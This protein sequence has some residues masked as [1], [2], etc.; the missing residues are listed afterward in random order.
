LRTDPRRVRSLLPRTAVVIAVALAAAGSAGCHRDLRYQPR[1]DPLEKSRFFA[2]GIGARPIPAGTVARGQL[3]EDRNFYTGMAGG[4]LADSFPMPVTPELLERGRGRYNIYCAPCHDQTG[5]G[6]G[7]VVRRGY[8]QPPSFHID[9]LRQARPGYFFDV[10]TN[11]FAKMPSYA[12]QVPAGD[13]WAIAAYIRALQ[14]SQN[15][16]L[17]DVPGDVRRE[18]AAEPAAGR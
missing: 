15:A 2:D 16:I 8:K 17:D 14:L 1:I 11:G 13:R 5:R 3:K 12:A 7:M 10:M 6:L 4:E 18:L 9:R